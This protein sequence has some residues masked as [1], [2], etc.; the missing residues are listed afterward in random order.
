MAQV[1]ELLPSQIQGPE[2]KPRT[3]KKQKNKKT[4]KT[5]RISFG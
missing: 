1:I 3:T 2:F 5:K 4:K